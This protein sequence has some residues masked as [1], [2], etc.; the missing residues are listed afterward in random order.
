MEKKKHNQYLSYL[1][2]LSGFI[3]VVAFLFLVGCKEDSDLIDE[4]PEETN[5]VDPDVNGDGALNILV[6]GTNSSI[7][8]TDAFSPDQIAEE[9]ESILS[10]DVS[11]SVNVTAEDIHMSKQIDTGLG[12]GGT[13]FDY[14][15]HSH[16][17]AQYYYWPEG[18]DAR[19]DNLKGN[20]DAGWDYVVIGADPYMV[21]TIPGYYSLG[22]NKIASKV[23]EGGA[24]PLLLMVWPKGESAS[25]SIDHFEEFTYRTADG[26]K[27]EL[28]TIPAGLAWEAL[29]SNKKDDASVHPSPNGAYLAAA[30]IY[31]QILEKSASS[32]E[33]SYDSELAEVAF[34]TVTNEESQVHYTDSR[35]F[36]SP[37]KSC[38]IDDDVLNYNHTGSSS[39]NGIRGG[40]NWI[41]GQAPETLESGGTSPI[42]FNYGRANSNFEADKR[43]QINPAM[44][45]FSFGFPMQDHGD[46]GD[47]SMLYGLDK[48]ESGTTNDTDIGV[49]RFMVAES[50]LPHARAIPVRT[51]YAQMQ[52]VTPD[53]SAYRDSW[54]MHRDLD[55]SIGAY[56]YTLLTGN[57]VLGEEP[58]D[59]N[60]SE[61]RTW[62][63]SKIGYETAWNLMHLEGVA[64]SCN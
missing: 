5:S 61:W 15:Y 39:E 47:V 37:F 53:Q 43:Y 20:G 35:T 56:M 62:M 7:N 9:L 23:V 1:S 45:D 25:A 28:P 2:S 64:P 22:V 32:S 36:I 51:L 10:A 14:K 6:I 58:T 18:R 17:L 50:E 46:L 59:Q 54:H 24:L 49:A 31:S 30:T 38:D 34:S 48:R 60:S 40:L 33:Y 55:K 41:F 57:C 21:S 8:G 27:V 16:S 29:P 12:Q 44:F 19:M 63:A 13:V 3:L 4:E 52:E 11:I 42:N 26:A